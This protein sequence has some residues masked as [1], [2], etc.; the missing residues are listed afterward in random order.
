MADLNISRLISDIYSAMDS[1]S[2]RWSRQQLRK[3][4]SADL[5]EELRRKKELQAQ[6][7][8]GL[9]RR[10]EMSDASALARQSLTNVGNLDVERLR[11]ES[12][13]DVAD[14]GAR[15]HLG[16]AEI[17][18]GATKHAADVGAEAHKYAADVGAESAE[19]VARMSPTGQYAAAA[20]VLESLDATPE[21]KQAAM[22]IILNSRGVDRGEVMP[23]AEQASQAPV[24][25]PTA[26]RPDVPAIKFNES[27][28]AATPAVSPVAPTKPTEAAS[29]IDYTGK[30]EQEMKEHQKEWQAKNPGA[31]SAGGS[32][33]MLRREQLRKKKAQEEA[34]TGRA[35]NRKLTER[36]QLFRSPEAQAARR[37]QMGWD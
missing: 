26:S 9:N 12:S 37:K 17:H 23:A 6:L 4:R 5:D 29:E 22:E 15:S 20:R 21:Q 16:A 33:F 31:T 8:E 36:S 11:G 28:P 30:S 13:R 1:P 18:A 27:A 14:I 24:A 34:E 3:E 32:P 2:A 25:A 7:E 35:Y 19:N 10:Q